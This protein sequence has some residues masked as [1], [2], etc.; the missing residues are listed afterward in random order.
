MLTERVLH[1]ALLRVGVGGGSNVGDPVSVSGRSVLP[2]LGWGSTTCEQESERNQT[3]ELEI[4]R[5]RHWRV[6]LTRK[7]AQASDIYLSHPCFVIVLE[8]VDSR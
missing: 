6:S 1:P 4:N 8:N 5:L 3:A 7:R 2:G